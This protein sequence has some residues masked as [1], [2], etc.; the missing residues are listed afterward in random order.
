[1]IRRKKETDSNLRNSREQIDPPLLILYGDTTVHV[2]YF[3]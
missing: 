3:A 2:G 1:M